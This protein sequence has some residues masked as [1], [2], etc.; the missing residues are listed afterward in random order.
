MP[1]CQQN[2]G[3]L[4][5]LGRQDFDTAPINS[6]AGACHVSVTERQFSHVSQELG[7]VPVNRLI[8]PPASWSRRPSRSPT[9]HLRRRFALS[10]VSHLSGAADS[11][12]FAVRRQRFAA[13]SG[14][15]RTACDA[16]R[17]P[18][19]QE[20]PLGRIRRSFWRV[21]R[22]RLGFGAGNDARTNGAE[23][24]F[25]HQDRPRNSHSGREIRADWKVASPFVI[26]GELL[27][28]GAY[29]SGG[30][31]GNPCERTCA[32]K[33]TALQEN[34]AICLVSL[35]M[36]RCGVHRNEAICLGFGNLAS[37]FVWFRAFQETPSALRAF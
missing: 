7:G 12:G 22:G 18:S 23:G 36:I 35:A 10:T 14:E 31:R 26:I 13:I 34:R 20:G 6:V 8:S 15:D 33:A 30:N 3:R 29:P 37:D 4:M 17:G 24:G 16:A 32:I 2:H 27:P 21:R 25:G 9:P 5:P 11:L 28:L 1:S 19:G